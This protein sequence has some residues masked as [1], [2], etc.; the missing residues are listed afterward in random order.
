MN[1]DNEKK[2]LRTL[3]KKS[4]KSKEGTKKKSRRPNYSLYQLYH[5]LG[6]PRSFTL[7]TLYTHFNGVSI[8]KP[9]IKIKQNNIS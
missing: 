4:G 8:Y 6:D 7:P 1:E 5:G 2:K 9:L 3:L